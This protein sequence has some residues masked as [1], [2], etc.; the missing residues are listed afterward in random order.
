MESQGQG[1]RR[2]RRRGRRA[3]PTARG[4]PGGGRGSPAD[5]EGGGQAGDD[6]GVP[7][8]RSGRRSDGEEQENVLPGGPAGESLG[9]R[10]SGGD[11]T[12]GGG[13]GGQAG[14]A[15]GR[16]P[17][18][19]DDGVPDGRSGRRQTSDEKQENVLLGGPAGESPGRCFGCVADTAAGGGG[20]GE[21][22]IAS[23]RTGSAGRRARQNGDAVQERSGLEGLDEYTACPPRGA[24]VVGDDGEAAGPIRGVVAAEGDGERQCTMK[25]NA[26]DT[27]S[28]LQTSTQLA[29]HEVKLK[30]NIDATPPS[31]SPASTFL[32]DALFS[33][34]ITDVLD[35]EFY[36]QKVPKIPNVFHSVTHFVDSL[37]P[38]LIEE[39]RSVIKAALVNKT[40]IQ[41]CQL[42]SV[43]KCLSSIYYLDIDLKMTRSNDICCHHIARD[44]DICLLSTKPPIH[45][46]FD[47]AA[48]CFGMVIAVGQDNLLQKSFRVLV[49]ESN[50]L[51]KEKMKFVSFLT[52]IESNM[53]ISN[54]LSNERIHTA[55]Q[56]ILKIY[57]M[58]GKTCDTC[59]GLPYCRDG[60]GY[61]KY[62]SIISSLKC[63]HQ[64][65]TKIV[66]APPGTLKGFTAAILKE[67]LPLKSKVLICVPHESVL[68]DIMVDVSDLPL[69]PNKGDIL[70]LDNNGCLEDC[71][72]FKEFFLEHQSHELYC[73]LLQSKS[74]LKT[75]SSLL[76][77]DAFYHKGCMNATSCERCKKSGLIEFSVGFLRKRFDITLGHLWECLI[78]LDNH[79]EVF[80][81]L[82]GET[83]RIGELMDALE[84]FKNL[85][86]S[87]CLRNDVVEKVFGLIIE[88]DV[89]TVSTSSTVE[90]SLNKSR[91]DSLML[92]DNFSNLLDV[93]DLKNR[94]EINRFCVKHARII[95][96]TIDCTRQLHGVGMDPFDI[97]IV[98]GAG[99]IRTDELLVPLV[100]PVRHTLLVGDH[101]HVH[102]TIHS[103]I[104]QE[105]GY[106]VS[107]FERVQQLVSNKQMLTLQAAMHPSLSQ[108]PNDYFYN[109]KIEDDP[110]VKS[111]EYNKEFMAIKY[112]FYGFMDIPSMELRSRRKSHINSAAI[113]IL[114]Q[115][116]CEDMI[117]S[118]R[119]FKIGLVCLLNNESNTVCQLIS[120]E[121]IYD[122]IDLHVT[123]IDDLQGE[124]FDV[125]ILSLLVEDEAQLKCVKQNNLN[126]ALTSSRHCLW[127]VGDSRSL[128]NS[129]GIWETLFYDAKRR[130][131]VQVMDMSKLIK[132]TEQFE[133]NDK[134]CCSGS[135][136]ISSKITNMDTCAFQASSGAVE[137]LKKIQKAGLVPPQE[138]NWTFSVDDM[139]DLYK[140]I[141]TKPFGSEDITAR[142]KKRLE[143]ALDI[144]QKHGVLASNES[145]TKYRRFSISSY[146]SVD[147][148]QTE[149][150]SDILEKG[151][152]MVG[153]FR[154]SRNYY[155]LKP[156]Q[157]YVF[158]KNMPIMHPQSDLVA[159]H[160][161][162]MIG[163]GHR[164]TSPG[165]FTRHMAIQNSEGELFGINGIGKVGKKTVQ[166]L[167][168]IHLS[169]A[170]AD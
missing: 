154:L 101:L 51:E 28:I 67:F 100:L 60:L 133:I 52:N 54:I 61:G 135:S 131:C 165:R 163:I 49:P 21:E 19:G 15:Q 151:G 17:R 63:G 14:A 149:A 59:S 91:I 84:N 6:D 27:F 140:T 20:H 169:G 110:N 96:S 88:M 12:A 10:H 62:G 75:M 124:Y 26:G 138:F 82:N 64:N 24:A 85:L 132:V 81:L 161:V 164:P 56:G 66:W 122:K 69:S 11:G 130:E 4:G 1:S 38:H 104:C 103:K 143:V 39:T 146:A 18:N 94:D 34:T 31:L 68:R 121:Q 158:D 5:R 123:S 16:A 36:R 29:S 99:Q 78:Y 37:K 134:G 125:I 144:Y 162:M 77:L 117:N 128:I 111:C 119:K 127:I 65:N 92:I 70:V 112:P 50:L 105:A 55:I 120:K 148:T 3:E 170:T 107:I 126:V 47:P 115:Q 167:Y 152:I 2:R 142:G 95:V 87:T 8:R 42:K 48:V 136:T 35:D 108:F 153:H 40:G 80:H 109:G 74:W 137:S 106:G 160:A 168:R 129:G 150:V 76:N 147:P 7:G 44:Y 9:R 97:L 145:A 57:R 79:T 141:V 73:F 139:K 102:P 41:Y 156:R 30:A 86:H 159:A 46:D 98:H 83:G 23:G 53:E 22:E 25:A 93:P 89:T 33:W 58:V 71:N 155:S 157:V 114:L 45:S 113:F 43:Q 90:Y 118:N 13:G 166:G 32:T 72:M 116:F